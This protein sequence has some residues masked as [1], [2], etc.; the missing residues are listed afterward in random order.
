MKA[1]I[2][3][4]CLA[5]GSLLQIRLHPHDHIRATVGD[6]RMKDYLRDRLVRCLKAEFIHMPRFYIVI[7]DQDTQGTSIV[8]PHVHGGI[9]IP[10]A[11]VPTLKDGRPTVRYRRLIERE[12]IEEAELFAGRQRIIRALRQAT[13]NHGRLPELAQ[14]R[15]QLNNVWKRKPYRHLFNEEWVSYALKNMNAVSPSLPENRLS[16]TRGLNQEAQRLWN[17]IRLGESAIS[18]WP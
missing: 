15:S 4:L 2:A 18:N 5:E 16:M 7:E 3:A 14:G 1:Q 12:S 6:R 8:R 17:L 9:E 10:R 11:A 13:G